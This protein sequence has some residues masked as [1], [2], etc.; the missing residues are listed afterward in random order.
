ML[1]GIVQVKAIKHHA[2]RGSHTARCDCPYFLGS[3]LLVF[4]FVYCQHPSAPVHSACVMECNA[5]KEFRVL[6]YRFIGALW[7]SPEGAISSVH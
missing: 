7:P 4:S 3:I 5:I 2:E 6:D 1:G